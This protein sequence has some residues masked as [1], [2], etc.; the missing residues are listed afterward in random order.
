MGDP[1]H[2]MDEEALKAYRLAGG[3]VDTANNPVQY[4]GGRGALA[5]HIELVDKYIKRVPKYELIMAQDAVMEK[6]KTVYASDQAALAAEA[7]RELRL[8]DPSS[9]ITYAHNDPATAANRGEPG[10]S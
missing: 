5:G 6:S 7:E 3:P 1:N 8:F 9:A 4:F 10:G 2:N